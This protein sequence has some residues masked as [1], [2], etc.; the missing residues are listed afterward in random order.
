ML[1]AVKK[2]SSLF[3]LQHF[4]FQR[5]YE[6]ELRNPQQYKQNLAEAQRRTPHP[7]TPTPINSSS[8]RRT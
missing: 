2:I 7:P 5:G 8:V 3:A 4:F 1:V 6:T